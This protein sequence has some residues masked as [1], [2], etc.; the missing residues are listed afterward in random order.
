MV[1]KLFG[2]S[3]NSGY[4]QVNHRRSDHGFGHVGMTLIVSNETAIPSKPTERALDHPTLRKRIEARAFFLWL[5]DLKHPLKTAPNQPSR[6]S[7]IPA[8]S[9]NDLQTR[10]LAEQ[11]FQ[12][13]WSRLTVVLIS[14]M[15]Y[16][17]Q[18]QP[19][20]IDDYMSLSTA[21]LFVWISPSAWPALPL[22]GDRLGVDTEEFLGCRAGTGIAPGGH[23][24]GPSNPVAEPLKQ[25]QTS[26]LSEMV[27]HGLPGW[28]SI[29]EH[30]PLASA[31]QQIKHS[32]EQFT[33]I[34]P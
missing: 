11:P 19:Q 1:Q 21:H 27:V 22:G 20:R 24:S 16:N 9:K 10:H 12:H 28:K 7:L 34:K 17:G 18:K 23:A 29:G 6:K 30:P 26:P 13:E 8:I 25:I 15:H 2:G 33:G 4:H 3:G 32:I 5:Y 31:F 14:R